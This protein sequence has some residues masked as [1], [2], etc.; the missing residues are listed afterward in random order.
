MP[1]KFSHSKLET[2]NQCPLKYKIKY[3]D[4]IK[5]EQKSIEGFL[6]AKVHETLEWLYNLVKKDKIPSI[7]EIIFHYARNWEN[8]FDPEIYFIVKQELTMKDYF[9]K[10]IKF[11][12]DYYQKNYPFD[13]NTIFTEKIISILLD[14]EENYRMTGIIDRIAYN[15]EK[16]EY[17]IHDYKTSNTLPTKEKIETDKQLPLYSIAIK[18]DY[19]ADKIQLIWHYLAYNKKI[20]SR[21]TDEQLIQLKKETL[22]L[23]KKIENTKFFPYNKSALCDW[24]EY[25][26]RCMAF[27]NRI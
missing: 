15:E 18:N 14:K 7:D 17:E 4:K 24:C 25:K 9:E 22:E 13:D 20:Y 16:R 3:I 11:L 2:F 27:G 8:D 10:G 12:L 23:I 5:T 26:N 6:G 21:R 1:E 19:N